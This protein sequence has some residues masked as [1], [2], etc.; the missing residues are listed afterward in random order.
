MSKLKSKEVKKLD[1]N[2]QIVIGRVTLEPRRSLES[3][4]LKLHSTA[5]WEL[6]IN[7]KVASVVDITSFIIMEKAGSFFGS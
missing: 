7:E 4:L 2:I 5:Y 3:M 1:E 6:E